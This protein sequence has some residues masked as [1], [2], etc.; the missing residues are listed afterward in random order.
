MQNVY[1]KKKTNNINSHWENNLIPAFWW[2]CQGSQMEVQVWPQ[3]LPPPQSE[4]PVSAWQLSHLLSLEFLALRLFQP[5][6]QTHPETNQPK[7]KHQHHLT[8]KPNI[9]VRLDVSTFNHIIRLRALQCAFSLV[10]A[11]KNRYVWA[12]CASKG[13]CNVPTHKNKTAAFS[14][15]Y[16]N[17]HWTFTAKLHCSP[18]PHLCYIH[19]PLSC[20]TT[21]SV[22]TQQRQ[23]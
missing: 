20:S 10:Y 22:H 12:Q 2:A 15:W 18:F 23:R 6:H 11:P 17:L 14:H 8:I 7:Q 5:H 9:K 3:A 16:C 13:Y 4:G 21:H 1:L 19:L